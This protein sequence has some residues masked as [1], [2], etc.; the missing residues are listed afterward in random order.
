MTPTHP[1]NGQKS[2]LHALKAFRVLLRDEL[3]ARVALDE[4]GVPHLFVL[5]GCVC[6]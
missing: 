6:M 1:S 5:R 2:Y 4:A 3:G